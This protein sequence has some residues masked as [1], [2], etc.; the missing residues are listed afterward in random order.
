MMEISSLKIYELIN[1]S[2]IVESDLYQCLQEAVA[3][4]R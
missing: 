4:I 1:Y 3:M 2:F